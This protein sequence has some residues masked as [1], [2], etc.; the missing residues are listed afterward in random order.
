MKGE[1]QRER[2]HMYVH[3]YTCLYHL[4]ADTYEVQKK[5]TD[6]PKAGD[7]GGCQLPTGGA[8][9]ELRSSER[10]ACAFNIL[11]LYTL[12]HLQSVS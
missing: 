12:S 11:E 3:T 7:T 2:E 5:A 4:Y 10:M 6:F 8:G 1:G 9:T